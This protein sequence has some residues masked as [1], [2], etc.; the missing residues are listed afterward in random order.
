VRSAA[1]AA[2]GPVTHSV[3]FSTMMRLWLG[4]SPKTPLKLGGTRTLP[5]VSV[6]TQIG[7]IPAPRAE[8]APEEEPPG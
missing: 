5:P 2:R 1:V 7:T 4:L 8:P 3:S 6:P